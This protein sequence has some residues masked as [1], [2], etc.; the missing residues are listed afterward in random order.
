MRYRWMLVSLAGLLAACGGATPLPKAS[1]VPT[2]LASP[3]EASTILSTSASPTESSASL[4]T[5]TSL[6]EVSASPT[7]SALP[8]FSILSPEDEAVVNVPEVEV[9]GEAEPETVITLNDEIVVVDESGMF[10]VTLLLEE[11]PNEIE[12][13]ASD[14]EGHEVSLILEVTYDPE[15]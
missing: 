8:G 9:V 14:L 2:I 4:P 13:V 5:A 10:S 12:V 11:G 6:P 3:T 1:A 7:P 15:S